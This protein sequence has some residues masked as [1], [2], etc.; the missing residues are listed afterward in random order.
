MTPTQT[1]D[2][3]GVCPNGNLCGMCEF[4]V[5]TVLA[6]LGEKGSVV[7]IEALLDVVCDFIPSPNG[8]ST[9]NCSSIPDLPNFDI[10]I[11]GQV[12]TLTPQQYI[13]NMGG[14]CV[15]GFIGLDIPQLPNLWILGDVFLRAYYTVFDAKNSQLGFATAK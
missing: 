4:V 9:V 14:E 6:V 13:L 15:S 3:I 12:L 1:C 8:E 7:E 5:E 11:N 10:T 2:A